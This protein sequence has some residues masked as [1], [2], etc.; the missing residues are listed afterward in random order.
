M[1]GDHGAHAE[2]RRRRGRLECVMWMAVTFLPASHVLFPLGTLVAGLC[3][4]LSLCVC[5]CLLS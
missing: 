3:L 5:V 2:W 4:C 1:G